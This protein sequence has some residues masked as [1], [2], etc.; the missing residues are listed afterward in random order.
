MAFTAATY[1][2]ISLAVGAIGA[3]V[4]AVGSAQQAKA[5]EA[6]S[7]QNAAMQRQ[8]SQIQAASLQAQAE[9]QRRQAADNLKLRQ[10]EAAARFGNADAMKQRAAAQ[11]E[12]NA[13][14][15]RLKREAGERAMATQRG[16]YAAAGIVESTGSPLSLIAE[17]AGII[18]RDLKETQYGNELAQS[19]LYHEAAMERL[20]G[21]YALA[22]ATLDRNSAFSEA[23]LTDAAGSATLLTGQRQAEITRLSGAAQA[24]G[25]RNQGWGNLLSYGASTTQQVAN[26]YDNGT[27]KRR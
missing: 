16:R 27:F 3:G 14:N 11:D 15:L 7:A 26:Y 23:R 4:S 10:G 21:E 24:Q 17:T 2:A 20:G 25:Y 6:I 5:S 12:I 19:G 8:N 18:E 13:R 9:I 1:A 22:G